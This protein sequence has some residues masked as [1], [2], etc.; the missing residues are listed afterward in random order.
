[1]SFMHKV[2]SYLFRW[3]SIH[4]LWIQKIWRKRNL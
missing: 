2:R 1:M 3:I 4:L